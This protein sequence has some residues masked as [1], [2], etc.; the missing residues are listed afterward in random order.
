MPAGVRW[1]KM[2]KM[3]FKCEKCGSEDVRRQVSLLLNPNDTEE[4][5]GQQMAQSG[6]NW[7]DFSYCLE[8]EDET[9]LVDAEG[10]SV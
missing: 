8:C 7:D 2:S 9:F 4:D 1:K 3:I 5:L 6:W 10:A